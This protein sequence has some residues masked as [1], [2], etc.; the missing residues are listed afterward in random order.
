MTPQELDAYGRDY[1]PDD[2]HAIADAAIRASDRYV[3]RRDLL[4]AAAVAD[5]GEVADVRLGVDPGTFFCGHHLANLC[6]LADAASPRPLVGFVHVPPDRAT[7]PHAAG[8]PRLHPR[9]ASLD[10][11]A[12]VVATALRHLPAPAGDWHILLTG[13]GPFEGVADNPTAAFVGDPRA[14]ARALALAFPGAAIVASRPSSDLPG[15]HHTFALPDDRRLHLLAAVLPLAATDAD[16]L[17]GRYVDPERVDHLTR[18]HWRE[19]GPHGPDAALGL[20]V[21]SSQ[22]G[23]PLPPTFK[24]EVQTRGWRRAHTRARTTTD[25]YRRDPALAL[26]FLRAR[27][28]ADDLL[29]FRG[30]DTRP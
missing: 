8:D 6:D 16:A 30:H 9:P 21:D 13:F 11:L 27:E 17:A 29:L 14:L 24:I 28:R 25:A 18:T 12:R 5:T 20:G 1:D 23:G 10:Q 15:A 4:H 7:G 19:A 22:I 2:A 3:L 26:A